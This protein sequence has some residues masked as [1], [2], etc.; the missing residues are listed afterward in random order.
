VKDLQGRAT[1][2]VAVPVED[3]FALIAAI[4]RYPTWFDIVRDAEILE[5][6]AQGHPLIARV[7]LY[8]PQSPFGTDFELV[9]AVQPEPPFAVHVSKLPDN[10]DDQDRVELSWRMEEG[11]STRIEFEFDAAVSFL[12]GFLP[13]GG[14]GDVVAQAILDAATDAFAW[15]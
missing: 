4:D 6:D 14:V 11:D 13:L 2:D 7:E 3:C 12:P 9:V 1:A 15:R 10:A 8:I 5:R